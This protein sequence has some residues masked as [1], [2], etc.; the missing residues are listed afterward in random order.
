MKTARELADMHLDIGRV[1]FETMGYHSTAPVVHLRKEGE[2]DVAIHVFGAID[3]YEAVV[4]IVRTCPYVPDSITVTGDICA[5]FVPDDDHERMSELMAGD[6]TI[7]R[8]AEARGRPVE[9]VDVVVITPDD[10]AHGYWVYRWTPVDGWEWGDRD[11]YEIREGSHQMWG[12]DRIMN[13]L[14]QVSNFEV[15]EEKK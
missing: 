4:D 2:D 13:G 14:P 8:F 6:S 10:Y 1:L 9:A 15:I 3:P 11:I 5:E 12:W 7:T